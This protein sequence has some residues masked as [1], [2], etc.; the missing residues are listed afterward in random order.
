MASWRRQP[1]GAVTVHSDQGSQFTGHGWQDF[2]RNHGLVCSMHRRGNCHDN[3]AA[4]SFFQHLKREPV[5]STTSRCSTTQSKSQPCRQPVACRV[6]AT[7]VSNGSRVS[8]E[9]E[10]DSRQRP[11]TAGVGRH[12]NV[13]S[14]RPCARSLTCRSCA[15][16][17]PYVNIDICTQV[18]LGTSRWKASDLD[19]LRIAR[20]ACWT[21]IRQKGLR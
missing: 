1:H 3:A 14:S 4:E 16:R 13:P 6:R 12:A 15:P 5:P 2:L 8:R 19:T 18:P 9:A 17:L 21:P 10:G 7:P 11:G 20:R